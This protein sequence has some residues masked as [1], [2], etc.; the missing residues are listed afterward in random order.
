MSAVRARIG[1]KLAI[2]GAVMA[3]G[4]CGGGGGGGGGGS[5]NPPPPATG[6]DASGVLGALATDTIFAT[7]TEMAA[8]TTDLLDAVN[9]LASG[10]VT[11]ATLES[12]QSTWI[13]AR[14]PWEA[15]EGFLWGPI[16][17]QGLDPGLDSWPVDKVQLDAVIASNIDLT[18]QAVIDTLDTTVKGFHT[19]EYLLF[20]DGTGNQDTYGCGQAASG[21]DAC[22]DNIIAALTSD[23]RRLDYLV[24]I[25][26]DVNEVAV[27]AANA[28]DTSEGDYITTLET[29]GQGSAVYASQRAVMQEVVQGLIGIT[30]EVANAGKINDPFTAH[31]P[32]TVESKFSGNS[33][34]DFQ[35]NIRSIRN[36]YCGTYSG[37]TDDTD[38]VCASAGDTGLTAFVNDHDAA[39]DATVRA[40]IDD[41]IAAIGQIP[42]PFEQAVIDSATDS[43]VEATIQGAI[44]A[45]N[46]LKAS[47]EGDVTDLVANAEFEF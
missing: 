1:S 7:Y 15:S 32:L 34:T 29:A 5:N 13:A 37:T 6:F 27:S 16:D 24:G 46:V 23:P 43:E 42:E 18:D 39:L 8:R 14:V 25:T 4:A 41:A 44:D 17:T 12:A 2:A 22:L 33:L 3:L 28:W 35:Y 31:D 30:D 19:I 38:T 9:V 11:R 20:N 40:E 10:N 45:I 47:L 26:I 21:T 36:V